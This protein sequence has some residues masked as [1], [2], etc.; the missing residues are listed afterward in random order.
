[1]L[2]Q[3]TLQDCHKIL[4]AHSLIMWK[5]LHIQL[6]SESVYMYVSFLSVYKL[7]GIESTTTILFVVPEKGFL[8]PHLG[9][10]SITLEMELRNLFLLPYW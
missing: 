10:E 5:Q 6:S 3:H 4:D 8:S 2:L 9:T 7:P 1:M